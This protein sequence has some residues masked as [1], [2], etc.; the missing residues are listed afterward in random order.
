[1][2]K[3]F[4]DTNILVYAN[5]NRDPKKQVLA[6]KLISDCIAER[7]GVISTQV[8]QEYAAVA[9][10]KLHQDVS[11]VL[12]RL[13][14]FESLEIVQVTPAFIRRALNLHAQLK[15]HYLDAT[16]VAAAEEA[17]CEVL[18]SE[19]CPSSNVHDFMRVVN[20]FA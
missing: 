19:D 12:R 17:G 20:P 13:G 2:S 18:Y 9:L 5:D 6:V 4:L 7:K 1:V 10:H 8:M 15:I 11:I 14:Q 3:F 16:V